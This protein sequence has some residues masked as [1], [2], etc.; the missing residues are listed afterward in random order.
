MK[1]KLNIEERIAL[2]NVLPFQG[3]VITLKIIRD[4]QNSLSFSEEEMKH[5]KMKNIRKPDGTTFAVWDSDFTNETKEIEIGEVA[6][7]IIVGQLK[8]L[9]SKKILRMEMLTLY[10]KFVKPELNPA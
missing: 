8:M 9:E 5:F 7:G 2:L 3:D 1:Y 4:L 6:E 10:E